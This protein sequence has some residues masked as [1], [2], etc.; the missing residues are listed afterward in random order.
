MVVM[1]K[2]S[3]IKGHV[4]SKLHKSSQEAHKG[5]ARLTEWQKFKSDLHVTIKLKFTKKDL[6]LG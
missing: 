1:H 2:K 5:L 3:K 4:C 6:N